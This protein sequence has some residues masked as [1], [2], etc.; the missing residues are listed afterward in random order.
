MLFLYFFIIGFNFVEAFPVT[1]ADYHFDYIPGQVYTEEIRVGNKGEEDLHV[2]LFVEGEFNG[3]FK[4]SEN[5]GVIPPGEKI[6]FTFEFTV[7]DTIKPG[8]HTTYINIKETGPSFE[9]EGT[10]LAAVVAVALPIT[11]RVPYPGKYLTATL[12]AEDTI[13]NGDVGFVLHLTS[14]GYEDLRGVY[15]DIGIYDAANSLID[16][17]RTN[18]A[19]VFTGLLPVDIFA[20]WSSVGQGIGIYNASAAIYYG[21][22]PLIVENSFR[23]GDEII[24]IIDISG[25]DMRS[26][27]IN[28]LEV[29][30]ESKWNEE[31]REVYAQLDFLGNEKKFTSDKEEVGSWGTKTLNIYVD[32][33][34]LSSGE[35]EAKVSLFYLNKTSEKEVIINISGGFGLSFQVILIIVIVALFAF[36]IWYFM[37]RKKS[38]K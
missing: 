30:A 20:E 15:A 3:S 23:I 35:Y 6:S 12:N 32:T 37:K 19:D 1:P 24:E 10:G 33:K 25:T 18:E 8:L 9:Q 17:V 14:Y 26:G 34:D 7:P 38:K 11:F 36:N 2:V 31:V 16:S 21:V 4:L 22:E 27:Q 28:L 13:L 29:V 5:T